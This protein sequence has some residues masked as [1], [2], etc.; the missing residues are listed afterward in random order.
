MQPS[1]LS[2]VIV[3][4]GAGARLGA[5]VP[6]AFVPLAG[7]PLFMHSLLQ[8]SQ[9]EEISSIILVTTPS[10]IEETRK[11]C[12]SEELSSRVTVV[13]GGKERWESVRNGVK[14]VQSEW[15]LVHDAA[16]P[17]V[18]RAVIDA[19]L[20]QKD[21]YDCVITV[22]PEVDTIREY[23]D[24]R[25]MQ[26]I[27]R[28]RLVRVGTPQLFRVAKLIE[29]FATVPSLITLPTDEAM[30]MQAHSIEV[31]IAWGDPLNFK[32]TTPGDLTLAEAL[33][34]YRR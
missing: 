10:M 2:V 6:K 11:L 14:A 8:F 5:S 4:G 29:A 26:A 33:C 34:A 28:S 27:D 13:P 30:L 31:G 24:G 23:T 9:H 32:V 25:V 22:T 21:R 12:E 1:S 3:A 19:V 20:A 16:R 17:F 7:K 18:S 15:V